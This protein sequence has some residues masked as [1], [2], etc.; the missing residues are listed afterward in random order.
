VTVRSVFLFLGMRVA[1][2]LASI[3][4]FISSAAK[5]QQDCAHNIVDAFGAII[6]GDTCKKQIALVFTGDEFADGGEIIRQALSAQ[7]IQASFFL[8]GR[9]YRNK[10]FQMLIIGLKNDGHY[11]GGH[12]DQHLLYND[13]TKRDSLLITKTVFRRDLMKN[14]AAMKLFGVRKADARYFIPP[15][16]WYNKTIVQW[17]S[18]MDIQTI[19]FSP[20]TRSTSDY[21]YPELGARYRTS[22]EIFESIVNLDRE[23]GLNGFILLIHIGVDSRR[24][25]K[26][27][28]KL[29]LL[30]SQLKVRGYSFARIDDFLK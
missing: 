2:F 14:F 25:D 29:D 21:T 19:N 1:S 16:E 15:Y 20:G 5:A 6:R 26:F 24:T 3:L 27:Y 22:D 18:E 28:N 23:K 30:L 7:K 13:W 8:T 10:N 17:A 4:I 11:L 9:F 12:S